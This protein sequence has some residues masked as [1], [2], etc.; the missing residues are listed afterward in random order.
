[1]SVIDKPQITPTK[2]ATLIKPKLKD[3]QEMRKTFINLA[4]T[5]SMAYLPISA[6]AADFYDAEKWAQ[7]TDEPKLKAFLSEILEIHNKIGSA[8][9]VQARLLISDGQDI[10]AF[11]TEVKG[12]KLIVLHMGLLDATM[13]DR[14]AVAAVLAHEYGHHAKNHIAKSKATGGL[15]SVLGAVAGALVDRKLGG[16]T[17]GQKTMGAGAEIISAKFDRTQ[18]S[19]ADLAGL[20]WLVQEGYNPDGAVRLQNKFLEMEGKESFSFFQSHPNSSERVQDLTKAIAANPKARDLQKLAI[21]ALTNPDEDEDEENNGDGGKLASGECPWLSLSV[22]AEALPQYR[23]WTV[24]SYSGPG[25]CGF[26]GVEI[27]GSNDLPRLLI[28][29]EYQPTPLAAAEYVKNMQ[30]VFVDDGYHVK[31]IPSLGKEGFAGFEK[32]PRRP[33]SASW[34]VHH[35]KVALRV[36]LDKPTPSNDKE[37]LVVERILVSALAGSNKP[38]MAERALSCPYLDMPIIKTLLPGKSLK[39]RQSGNSN[40]MVTTDD[41]SMVTV[42]LD[43]TLDKDQREQG[44]TNL[45]DKTCK[46]TLLPE[47]GRL[48]VMRHGCSAGTPYTEILFLKGA[49]RV[50]VRHVQGGKEPMSAIHPSKEQRDLLFAL[51]QAMLRNPQVR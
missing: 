22:V 40:C 19:E 34:Y 7:E 35:D 33:S 20:P 23:P 14:D 16:G 50:E 32:T 6:W 8:S 21:V 31:M 26:A 11:A 1:M 29:Q 39:V 36:A 42:S 17:L 24:E 15:L 28:Y 18:E 49:T 43:V 47:L 30:K 41:G 38:T 12:Q 44:M 4:L 25:L 13:Q 10:N 46:S 45:S 37:Q 9:G 27:P 3:E 2:G 51:A 48:A 5:V